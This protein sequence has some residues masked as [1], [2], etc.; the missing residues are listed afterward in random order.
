MAYIWRNLVT[1]S[2][3]KFKKQEF[4]NVVHILKHSLQNGKKNE[5]FNHPNMLDA[6]MHFTP[7]ERLRIVLL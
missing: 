3:L 2:G 7:R 1:T 6:C 5:R 4:D